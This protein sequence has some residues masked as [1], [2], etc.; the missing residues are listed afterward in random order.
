MIGTKA[1]ALVL[2]RPTLLSGAV[3]T[4]TRPVTDLQREPSPHYGW[5]VKV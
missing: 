1:Y 5:S 3:P 2:L 4:I